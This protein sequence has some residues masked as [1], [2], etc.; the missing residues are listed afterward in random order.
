MH[1]FR[2]LLATSALPLGVLSKPVGSTNPSGEINW[3]PCYGF[4][5]ITKV[6][7]GNLTVPLD[8]TNE[9]DTR[10][11]TLNL[12]KNPAQKQPAPKGSILLNYGGP[13]GDGINNFMLYYEKQRK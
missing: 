10:T 5:N 3:T 12:I 4:E 11:V 9:T 13:G 7:C 6:E 8:Y 1:L 2:T